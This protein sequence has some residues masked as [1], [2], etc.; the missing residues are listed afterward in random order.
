[1]RWLEVVEKDLWRM[2][3]KSWRRKAVDKE[4]WS[5]VIGRPR[6]SEGRRAEE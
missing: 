2:K 1:M 4:E 3:V 5:S 6:L